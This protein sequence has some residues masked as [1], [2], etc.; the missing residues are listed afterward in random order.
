[1]EAPHTLEH[2]LQPAANEE[3]SAYK[4]L[5]ANDQEIEVQ[6][7]QEEEAKGSHEILEED[8]EQFQR[9]LLYDKQR[10][11]MSMLHPSEQQNLN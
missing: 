9:S 10:R 11:S 5:G 6:N 1:M 8:R 7:P 3:G 2:L 4:E